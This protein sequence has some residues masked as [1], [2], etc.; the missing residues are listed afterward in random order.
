MD[1]FTNDDD[2]VPSDDDA[3]AD[4]DSAE[5]VHPC[6]DQDW[7]AHSVQLLQQCGTELPEAP[8]LVLTASLGVNET[9]TSIHAGRFTDTNGDGNIDTTDDSQLWVSITQGADYDSHQLLLGIDETEH[10]AI[11]HDTRI[12]FG[13]IGEIDPDLPGMEFLASYFFTGADKQPGQVS[14]FN[15]ATEIWTTLLP[16]E[17]AV[18]PWLTDLDGDGDAELLVDRYI[19][20]ATTGAIVASLEGKGHMEKTISADLD[21]DGLEE[22]IVAS[23]RDLGIHLYSHDGS[24]LQICWN[25][26]LGDYFAGISF[27]VGNLD[28]DPEGEVFVAASTNTDAYHSYDA[29]LICDTDG[30]LIASSTYGLFAPDL[31]GLGELDGDPLPEIVLSDASGLVALDTDLSLLWKFSRDVEP[32]TW[33]YFPFALADLTGDGFH[34]VVSHAGEH[35]YV[36]DR[37]GFELAS[38]TMADMSFSGPLPA[39]AVVDVDADGL[40]EIVVPN[41]PLFSII[42]SPEGGWPVVD[43]EYPWPSI[44]KYPGDRTIDGSVTPPADVHWSDPQSNV[45]Q[46]VARGTSPIVPEADLAVEMIDVC[47]VEDDPDAYITVYVANQGHLWTVEDVVV[48]LLAADGTFIA[49]E[50]VPPVLSPGTALPVHFVV[51]QVDVEAGFQISIDPTEAILECDE[52][53]NGAEGSL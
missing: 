34:E 23:G 10:A 36:V 24:M 21:L 25:A 51:P 3:T 5:P 47:T 53:N 48:F 9:G 14:A 16:S 40:A 27:A 18:T 30:S 42:E 6:L 37:L 32:G 49:D 35:L 44:D 17:G 39:P 38:V 19:I 28:G 50:V 26:P 22:I 15:G 13:T 46:G 45:W 41:W 33:E 29:V 43:S 4:D 31:A 20:D 11:L 12:I 2:D 52:G 8:E 1:G 7:P